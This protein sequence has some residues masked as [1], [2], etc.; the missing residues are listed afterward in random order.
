MR[1]LCEIVPDMGQATMPASNLIAGRYALQEAIGEGGMAVVWKASD[2]TLQRTVAVKL[3]DASGRDRDA[4]AERFLREARLAA[5][6]EHR[7]VVRVVDFGRAEDGTPF[8]V[9]EFL[10]GE[11]LADYL[12]RDPRPPIEEV[13]RIIALTLRGLEAVHEVGI[14]HRDIKPDNIFLAKEKEAEGVCPKLL[15]F[16]ISRVHTPASGHRSAYTTHEGLL[17]GTPQYMSP[18]QARGLK[19]IDN[20]ADLYSMGAVLYEALTGTLPYVSENPGDLLM[21]VIQG[22]AVSVAT[23]RPEIDASLSHVVSCAL[24][25]ERSER[26][27]DARAMRRALIGA[28][29]SANREGDHTSLVGHEPPSGVR[30]KPGGSGFPTNRPTV[31]SLPPVGTTRHKSVVA[32]LA[33]TAVL[34][35]A[36][37]AGVWYLTR[38]DEAE[39][40]PAPVVATPAP[41]PAPSAAPAPAPAEIAPVVGLPTIAPEAVA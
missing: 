26:Y 25:V 9:M 21:A 16:G 12:F 33:A 35:I 19:D 29:P 10:K 27:A 11:S 31:D 13:V 37:A 18:E 17:I 34:S 6:V 24:S 14:V 1:G 38:G 4:L 8:M 41:P 20:R 39:V 15:D 32:A 40:A 23:L 30:A 2:R 22:G 36:A 5:A 7:H 3:L 28:V